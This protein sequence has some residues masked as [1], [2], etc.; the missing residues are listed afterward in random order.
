[1]INDLSVSLTQWRA[2]SGQEQR[3]ML[4]RAPAKKKKMNKQSTASIEWAMWSWNPVTGCKHNCAYCY[5]RDMANRF[6]EH[7]FEPALWPNRLDAPLNQRVP[8]DQKI[9]QDIANK[10][11]FVCSMADLFGRWVPQSWIERVLTTVENAPQWEFMFLTKFPIRLSE[12]VYTPNAIVGASVDTQSR[13]SATMKAFERVKS[14]TNVASTWLSLEPLLEPLQFDN[15]AM[16]DRIVIGGA[17][18]S[19]GVLGTKR[20]PAWAPPTKWVDS[21]IKQ[22]N[23]DGCQVFLKDNLNR[24][25]LQ[26]HEE[27][28]HAPI[29]LFGR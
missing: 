24:N 2:M 12:Q 7:K 21:L 14:K 4:T 1:M 8:S 16:F 28:K 13:V 23:R 10:R 11:V 6:Y 26:T 19:N 25:T 22:A 27:S 15:L 5:A 17:R 3:D 29:A 20:T 18:A 9:E